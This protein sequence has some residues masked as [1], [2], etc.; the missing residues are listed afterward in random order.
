MP[1]ADCDELLLS[2]F[3][4]A[5]L[6]FFCTFWHGNIVASVHQLTHP[7][8]PVRIKYAIQVAEMWCRQFGSV[9]QS[10]FSAPRLQDLFCTATEA[11]GKTARQSWDADISFLSSADGARYDRLLF[12]KFEAT[13]RGR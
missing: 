12:E 3:F 4:L 8:P 2:C 5:V 6:A 9:P 7:P 11:V 13:R 10:W 1:T